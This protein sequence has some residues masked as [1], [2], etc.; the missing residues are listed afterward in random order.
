MTSREKQ[1]L[2]NIIK[3]KIGKTLTRLQLLD[4]Y[5]FFNN[6]RLS[7]AYWSNEIVFFKKGRDYNDYYYLLTKLMENDVKYDRSG[8]DIST[9]VFDIL[10]KG[11]Q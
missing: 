1:A 3:Y 7:F 4:L 11:K 8:Q 5:A 6:T 9:L 10:H 2:V